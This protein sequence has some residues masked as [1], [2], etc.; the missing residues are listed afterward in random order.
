MGWQWDTQKNTGGLAI[1]TRAVLIKLAFTLIIVGGIFNL[2]FGLSL[3]NTLLTA[4]IVTGIAY[5]IGDLWVFPSFG[6][7]IATVI[8]AALIGITLWATQ[9]VLVGFG[10]QSTAILTASASL[11]VAEWFF[12]SYLHRTGLV[13]PLANY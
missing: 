12:H 10:I 9:L 13:H 4:L 1:H 7:V 6:N 3:F 2:W 11:A 5:V 8:D